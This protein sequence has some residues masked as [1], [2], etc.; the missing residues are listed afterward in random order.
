VQPQ[1]PVSAASAAK[2]NAQPAKEAK[3]GPTPPPPPVLAVNHIAKEP[4]APEQVEFSTAGPPA[5]DPVQSVVQQVTVKK[6][7]SVCSTQTCKG[8]DNFCGTAVAFLPSPKLA[9]EEAA[10][11]HKLVFVLHVSG[12]FEDPGFT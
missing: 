12:N 7:Q 5:K 2:R 11:Q 8:N 6:E 1:K 10:K 4:R 9:E 3:S